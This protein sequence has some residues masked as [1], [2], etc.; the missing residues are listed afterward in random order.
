MKKI[1]WLLP[2]IIIGFLACNKND[3]VTL[4][5]DTTD[6][7]SN[8][9]TTDKSLDANIN[10]IVNGQLFVK[11]NAVLTI[12]AGTTISFVKNDTLE[13]KSVMVIT[14][15]AKLVISG[16]ADK[17]VIFTSAA[18]GKAAGD[19]GALIL[20][21]KAPTNTGTGHVEGLPVSED[22]KYGG[23]VADDNS[24][25][26]KYLRLEYSGGINPDAEDEWK[27]DKA[28]GLLLASVGNGTSVDHVMVEHSNDDGFQFV[29][30][31][32]NASYLVAFN[33]GDDDFDFD[34]GY[35]GNLQFIVAY[36][37]ALTSTHAL[38]ANAFE[39]YNDEVPTNNL[40][41]TRPVVSNMSIV[42]PQGTELTKTNLNQG[43][44]IRKGTRFVVQNSVVAEYPQGALMVCIR[45]RPILLN[46]T[47]ST[48][49]Y[50]LVQSD[51]A[52]TTFSWDKDSKVIGDPEL[53]TFALN[54]INNNTKYLS[55]S[56]IQLKA[57]YTPGAPDL[58]PATG[59]PA[60]T[61]ANFDGADFANFFQKVTY[62]GA[63]GADNWAAVSN[64]ANWK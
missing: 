49:K 63:F 64:W 29:G 28:S 16:T 9:I 1:A 47:Q 50:N 7:L 18:M 38:R 22:T 12:P 54:N 59:S 62:R 46:T 20:L 45:T 36:R 61:G 33:N 26:I 13:K 39:S 44:Y 10:Y 3:G 57:M 60:L 15:G 19:W 25:S 35:T 14:Q 55:S 31:T 17:P 43:V 56:E 40:P 8:S 42:G 27:V 11:N 51:N 52:N 6:T 32:V 30:G 21:G 37:P 2:F 34:L 48:F 24:G 4:P 58:T 41:Y 5:L 23:T 53:E